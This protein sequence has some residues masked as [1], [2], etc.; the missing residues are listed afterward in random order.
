MLKHRRCALAGGG[1]GGG[2]DNRFF[3]GECVCVCVGGEEGGQVDTVG[4]HIFHISR[5]IQF[6]CYRI[7]HGSH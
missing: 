4:R 3:R 7:N 1:G 5:N 6:A 2:V